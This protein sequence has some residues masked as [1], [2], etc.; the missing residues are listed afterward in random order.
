MKPAKSPHLAAASAALAA[1]CMLGSGAALRAQPAT[2]ASGPPATPASAPPAPGAHHAHH[3]AQQGVIGLDVYRDGGAIHVLTAEQRGEDVFLWH[4]RSDDAGLTW[5]APIRVDGPGASPRPT[6][7]GDEAQIAAHGDTVLAIWSVNGTGW[8]KSGPLSAALSRDGGKTWRAIAGPSDSGMAKGEGFADLVA[9][10]E[11]FHAVWLDG[12]DGKQGLRYSMLPDG[13][14]WAQNTTISTG[15]CECCWN[16]LLMRDGVLQ[17]LFRDKDPR[18]MAL[19]SLENDAW[20]KRGSVGAFGWRIKGCP[21]TGGGLA[22]TSDGRLHALVWTGREGESG[23]Y[24]MR[25]SSVARWSAPRRMGGADAQHGD[26]ASSGERLGAVWDDSG[27]IMAAS[28]SDSGKTWTPA[29]VVSAGGARA[30][31]PRVVAAGDA[32]L[33][34]WTQ[35][36][37]QGVRTLEMKKFK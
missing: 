36:D 2:P 14:T 12:R 34:L 1:L 25:T 13:K 19:A 9:D 35:A 37:A 3:R 11:A 20:I 17:V 23:L 30:E 21:E 32:F 26:L 22:T 29:A 15:T 27:R 10:K 16:T 5:S 31:N 6:R 4:R 7:R 28:S 24:A 18:D 33:A 8:G